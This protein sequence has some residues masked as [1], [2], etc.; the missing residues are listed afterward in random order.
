[1]IQCP[2]GR[3]WRWGTNRSITKGEKEEERYGEFPKGQQVNG[4]LFVTPGLM[5]DYTL[6]NTRSRSTKKLPPPQ[7]PKV[8]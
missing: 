4:T 8:T 2:Q 7:P 1:L 3:E 5:E 6:L